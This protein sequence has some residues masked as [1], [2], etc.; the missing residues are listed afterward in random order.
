MSDDDQKDDLELDTAQADELA[1]TPTETPT[2]ELVSLGHGQDIGA[3]A[4]QLL[5][6]AEELG[7]HPHT[8][9]YQ[10]RAG[11]FVVPVD[12]AAVY[13]EQAAARAEETGDFGPVEPPK[14]ARQV[15]KATVKKATKRAA[16]KAAPAPGPAPEAH[17][18]GDGHSG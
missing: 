1:D 14:G 11:G 6:I 8:V 13:A 3:L 17:T 15:R 5:D 2:H 12:V 16:K 18:E 4:R 9:D 10:P 7:L